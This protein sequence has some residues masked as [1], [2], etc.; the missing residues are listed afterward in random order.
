[1]GTFDATAG[2]CRLVAGA[3]CCEEVLDVEDEA[4]ST[5]VS[6]LIGIALDSS[7]TGLWQSINCTCAVTGAKDYG[8]LIEQ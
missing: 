2:S 4:S 7:S 1:V 3:L 6:V 5:I 8:W